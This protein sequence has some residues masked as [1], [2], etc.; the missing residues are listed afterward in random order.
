MPSTAAQNRLPSMTDPAHDQPRI[1]VIIERVGPYHRARME[2][3]ARRVPVLA[4]ETCAV[5]ETY[6]WASE[7]AGAFARAT[8]FPTLAEARVVP[9]LKRALDRELRAFKPDVIAIPGWA[10]PAGLL[11]FAWARERGT[12]VIIISDSQAIDQRRMPIAEAV[13][14]GV[15]GMASAGF[16]AGRTH[17][18]YLSAL[19][20][21]RDRIAFGYDVV[22]NDHFAR[23]AEAAR[24]DPAIRAR[25]DLPAR[26][27]ISVSRF[28]EK[29]NLETLVE[30]HARWS[31]TVEDP[32]PLVLVGD[33][34]LRNALERQAGP[35]VYLR[36]FA[37]YSELPALYGLAQAFILPST[38]EQWGLTVNEA[39]AAGCPVIASDRAGAT[40]E[41]VEDGVTG[42]V[43]APTVEGLSAAI[44]RLF[45]ADPA[46]LASAAHARIAAWGPE[47]FVDG[48]LKAAWVAMSRRERIHVPQPL[49]GI[50]L[51]ALARRVSA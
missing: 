3:L 24:A 38:V 25:L 5:D 20:M 10:D 39:M 44:T 35:A 21:P 2:A 49:A 11:A 7:T 22:D 30:A 18:D 36:S 32:V 27:L 31:Q 4:I 8:L 13:K 37:D 15:V 23:G 47:R 46:S 48:M 41:L 45:Q 28:V 14:R 6:L 26:Y 29:K 19:G 50:A 51:A 33:G 12:P 34:P 1:A 16:V 17:A 9:R 43:A 40:A 42:I